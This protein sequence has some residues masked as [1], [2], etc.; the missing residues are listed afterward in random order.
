MPMRRLELPECAVDVFTY[1]TYTET[2]K[3]NTKYAHIFF[4]KLNK[5]GPLDPCM[6]LAYQTDQSVKQ[7]RYKI[8]TVKQIKIHIS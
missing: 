3:G 1:N 6:F 5:I 2:Y 7:S 8:K 4:F